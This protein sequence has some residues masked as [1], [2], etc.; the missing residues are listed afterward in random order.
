MFFC[1]LQYNIHL[2]HTLPNGPLPPPGTISLE[3]ITNLQLV[4][5]NENVKYVFFS[6]LLY[7]VTLNP[8]PLCKYNFPT[9]NFD[10]AIVLAATLTDVALRTLQDVIEIFADNNNNA[11][12][13]GIAS[14]KGLIP[15]PLPFLTTSTRDFA[16]S[17]LQAFIVP[18]SCP[19]ENLINLKPLK[20][21]R[22]NNTVVTFTA[23]FPFEENL[24]NSLT[25]AAVTIGKG[26]FA[27]AIDIA[28]ASLFAPGLI[29][30][31]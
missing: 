26:L 11:N 14:N 12:T 13:R 28:N 27:S 20:N 24:L 29:E 31:N 16:F 7:N 21:V 23:L 30:V 5:Y 25:I 19:N 22:V 17:T 10:N 8:I 4:E 9:T 1:I 3:G 2:L 18:G 6:S 15:N